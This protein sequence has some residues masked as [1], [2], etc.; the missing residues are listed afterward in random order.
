[1]A[2]HESEEKPRYRKVQKG[3]DRHGK[4]PIGRADRKFNWT[5]DKYMRKKKKVP[6]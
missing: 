4:R 2:F 3:K 6:L 1:M 5:G